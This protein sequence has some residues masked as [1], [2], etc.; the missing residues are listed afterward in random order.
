MALKN[1]NPTTPGR[2]G[3]VLVDR[4]DLW[5]GGPVKKLPEGLTKSGGRNN[6]GRITARRR[7][8]GHKRLYR[9]AAFKRRK[10]DVPAKVARLEYEPNRRAFIARITLRAGDRKSGW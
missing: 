5:K 9:I 3:L 1:F 6:L 2:R 10:F 4:G 7:G 8:G